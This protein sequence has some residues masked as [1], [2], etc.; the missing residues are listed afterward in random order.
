MRRAVLASDGSSSAEIEMA[1][2][3]ALGAP[4][5]SVCAGVPVRG[6]SLKSIE[7]RSVAGRPMAGARQA[8]R[9]GE[10]KV[11]VVLT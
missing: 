2:E 10:T 9:D 1:L 8:M 11:A 5:P 4:L 7:R 6:R 3:I